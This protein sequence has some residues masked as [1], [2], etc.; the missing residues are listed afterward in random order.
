MADETPP[1]VKIVLHTLINIGFTL[2]ASIF[3][4]LVFIFVGL[5]FLSIYSCLVL[6]IVLWSFFYVVIFWAKHE[7]LP[8]H[9][10][11]RFLDNEEEG[12]A[13]IGHRGGAKEAPE[14]TLAAIEEC[15]VCLL[16]NNLKQNILLDRTVLSKAKKNGAYAVEVDI[17][18]T[19]DGVA[20]L[21]HDWTVDR[22]TDGVG[23]ISEMTLQ[24]AKRLNAAAKF[25]N[26]SKFSL[27]VI[28]TLDECVEK[29][30]EL[31]LK[32]FFDVKDFSDKV[33]S[34]LTDLYEKYPKLL[35]MGMVCSFIPTV[36]YKLRRRNPEIL[37]ALTT[38]PRF[39]QTEL[40]K[41]MFNVGGI[42]QYLGYI[43]DSIMVWC[44]INWLWYLCGNSAV[45]LNKDLISQSVLDYWK[46]RGIRVVPWTVNEPM[47]KAFFLNFH[48]LAIITDYVLTQEEKEAVDS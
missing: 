46:A 39:F 10:I 9:R 2:F 16:D 44:E 18:I 40:K 21:L 20:V 19:K 31:N 26:R 6:S 43:M 34:I 12:D 22:T 14:N 17:G 33:V 42:P 5:G 38:S 29:C 32:I 41:S 23:L 4:L 27:E 7:K 47:Q 36:V 15:F 1:I 11:D 48:Q 3:T 45:L 28:P 37:T 24:E 35:D 25:S 8:S 13:I 30:L